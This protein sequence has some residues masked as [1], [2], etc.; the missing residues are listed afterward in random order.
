MGVKLEPLTVSKDHTVFEFDDKLRKM[1]G[2]KNE[3]LSEQSL[4]NEE[5]RYLYR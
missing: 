3:E 4:H 1:F 5:L 2:N